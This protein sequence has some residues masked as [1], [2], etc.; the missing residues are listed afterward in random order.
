MKPFKL[1]AGFHEVISCCGLKEKLDV[2]MV[3]ELQAATGV[4]IDSTESHFLYLKINYILG[5]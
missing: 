5:I 3:E 2:C 4:V 1:E